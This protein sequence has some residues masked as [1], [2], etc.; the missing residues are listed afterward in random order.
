MAPI[1]HAVQTLQQHVE[2]PIVTRK[3]QSSIT[4]KLPISK[5]YVIHAFKY[6]FDG[7]GTLPGS[8][9]HLRLKPDAKPV[10]HAPR[11]VPEKKKAAY[12]A[13][14]ERLTHAEI[15]EKKDGHTIDQL[16]CT[17]SKARWF[18]SPLPR[19]EGSEQELG[20]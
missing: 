20:T 8:D 12:K 3:T 16:H 6:V 2:T 15:I 1:T 5:D 13:G 17:S 19:P 14:L 9:Y 7:L 4:H 10:Q 18:H 11:Q